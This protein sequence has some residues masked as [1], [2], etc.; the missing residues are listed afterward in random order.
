[1]L[2]AGILACQK[3]GELKICCLD[4][5]QGDGIVISAPEGA[6]FLVDGG[7]S[8]QSG[9]GRYQLIPYLKCQ[10]I[11]CLDGIILSHMDE[12]HI[13]GVKE[14]LEDMGRN[15]TNIRAENL[16]LPD[17]REESPDEIELKELARKAG[18]THITTLNP[19]GLWTE[20]PLDEAVKKGGRPC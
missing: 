4:V 11:S 16:Y 18:F 2:A 1:M 8:S 13:S 15:Q 7:S 12:D 5:G 9:V 10:G 17:L 14:L 19:E 20:I 3:R 6:H